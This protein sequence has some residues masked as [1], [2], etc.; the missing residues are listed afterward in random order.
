[1]VSSWLWLITMMLALVVAIGLSQSAFSFM[2]TSFRLHMASG[3]WLHFPLQGPHMTLII[4]FI[5]LCLILIVEF[6]RAIRNFR[7]GQRLEEELK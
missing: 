3:T 1:M 2:Q 5:L 4:G 6:A 7:R